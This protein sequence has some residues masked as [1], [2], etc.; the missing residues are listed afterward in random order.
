VTWITGAFL[1]LRRGIN[2][3]HGIPFTDVKNYAD[4]YE[5]PVTFDEFA[6]LIFE[7]ER[8]VLEGLKK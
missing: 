7:I 1:T 3:V 4:A 8:V 5:L 6:E 2:G